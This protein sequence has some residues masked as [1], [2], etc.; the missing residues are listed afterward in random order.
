MLASKRKAP[1]SA[2]TQLL[3]DQGCRGSTFNLSD[4]DEDKTVRRAY[5]RPKW[6]RSRAP[7]CRPSGGEHAFAAKHPEPATLSQGSIGRDSC[8]VRSVS[9]TAGLVFVVEGRRSGRPMPD[10]VGCRWQHRAY[11]VSGARCRSRAAARVQRAK[12]VLCQ[13]QVG[14]S[15]GLCRASGATSGRHGGQG[16]DNRPG[17]KGRGQTGPDQGVVGWSISRQS[18]GGNGPRPA[19]FRS[20]LAELVSLTQ[21]EKSNV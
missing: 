6:R 14:V 1:H 2:L 18:H 11:L 5:I 15:R 20:G 17:R 21:Q 9:D 4:C 19:A 13:M 8:V 7:G 10:R 16:R 12:I 3:F